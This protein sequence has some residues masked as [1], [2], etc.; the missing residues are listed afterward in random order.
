VA[1][2][3]ASLGIEAIAEG[4]ENE[5]QRDAL[6]QMGCHAY[7]GYLFGRPMPVAQFETLALRNAERA[8]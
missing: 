5:A 6:A 3:A 1:V 8:G 7:Q 4:V 2:L